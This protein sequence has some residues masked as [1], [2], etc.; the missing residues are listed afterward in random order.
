M[1][2]IF[3]T[4][5]M[6]MMLTVS[7]MAVTINEVAGT[8]RGDLYIGGGQYPDKEVYILPGMTEN[9]ITF[10]LPN[11][12]YNSA[13]LGNIV[14][15]NIPMDVAGQL[16][17]DNSSLYINA[18]SERALISV[19]NGLEDGGITYNSTVSTD[20][21]QVIL[22]IQAPSLPE[23]IFVLF[24][25]QKVTTDNYAIV[26]GGFEGNWSNNEAPKWHSFPSA[27]GDYSDFV[28]GN[29]QQFKQ[30]NEVRP[31]STG[32]H[33]VYLES[34]MVLS[35]KA[36][37]NC[38][39]GR[40]NAGSTSASDANG[41]FNFS[42][43]SNDG[44]NTPFVGQPDSMVFWAKYIPADK[45]PTNSVNKARMNAVITT[46]ARYQDPETGNYGDAKIAAATIDYAATSE[47]GWQR[48][49]VPFEYTTKNPDEAAYVLITFSTNYQPG[50]GSTYSKGGF[51]GIGATVYPDNLYLDDAEMIYNHS[52]TSLTMN[53]DA[54]TF[55]NGEA[56]S[57]QVF[58]DSLYTFAATTDGR[59]AQTF[60]AY[61]QEN[62]RVYIYVVADNYS[63]EQT[64]SVYSLQMVAPPIRY[65]YSASTCDNTPYTDEY[66]ENLT[67]AGEYVTSV[68][69]TKGGNRET[70]VTLTLS[71]MPTYESEFDM[72]IHEGDADVWEGLDLSAL[73]VGD[74]TLT[75]VYSSEENCDS[76][77]VL[78]LTVQPKAITT[79]IPETENHSRCAEKVLLNGRLY[80]IRDDE[81][82]DIL[83]IKI[84]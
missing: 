47:M 39:N 48:L 52:L 65:N 25:G 84:D 64:F 8:F 13:S 10:V 75:V 16:T 73:A 74:T 45:K 60:I 49:S 23:P 4:L 43:P 66:F 76:T 51:L 46:N 59:A 72:T 28:T 17:L 61:D 83:G 79:G 34:N 54:I 21:A 67:E 82:Y 56:T 22:S 31:G 40:V 27:V 62:F 32:Q 20:A 41:N 37:G 55:Q 1:K 14:L 29:T 30:S 77:L 68:N 57:D 33:S 5:S 38:T 53:G 24:N 12:S 18:I 80:I 58:S 11:F 35:A 6:A 2:K 9:T 26:N 15:P 81:M 19:L 71:V 70:I 3:L 63:Q 50:G 78:H 7:A 69:N 42:D 36:N 44:Y